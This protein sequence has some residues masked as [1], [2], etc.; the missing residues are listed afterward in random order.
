[1][2][3]GACAGSTGGGMKVARV[4]ILLKSAK[5]ELKRL[6]HPKSV[7]IVKVN[8]KKIKEAPTWL[9]LCAWRNILA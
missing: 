1:M 6:L 9:C 3:F 5:R 7:A 4:L 2:V 8:E